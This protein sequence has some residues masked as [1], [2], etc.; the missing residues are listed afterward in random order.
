MKR[1]SSI[2]MSL[3]CAWFGLMASSA[4]ATPLNFK[5]PEE[6]AKLRPSTLPGAAIAAQKCSI[7]HSADY[8]N[9]Q[10][11]G[12]SQA[13]WTAEM[14]KMQH[15]YGAPISDEEV[16]QLGAYLAVAY[17]SAKATDA[18]VLA[19]SAPTTPTAAAPASPVATASQKPAPAAAATTGP[20]IDVQAL[21]NN[22]ACLSC[23]AIAQKIV[24]P[25]YKD[26]AAKYKGD[27]QALSK[28]EV[29]IRKGSAGKWGPAPMPPFAALSDAQVKALANFVLK[30]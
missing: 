29:S 11:P 24:G 1:I 26:V 15:A 7:C 6:T 23:H 14:A 21:L 19:L 18:S 16:K 4:Q 3:A 20:V 13:Q 8:V 5:L 9:Y 2:T 28:L 10:P 12:M 22:N 30:Q 27:A 25:S 17:G